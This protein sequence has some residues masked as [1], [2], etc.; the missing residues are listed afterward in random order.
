VVQAFGVCGNCG[1][2]T[3]AQNS[4]LETFAA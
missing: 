1:K 3:F 2:T 4:E